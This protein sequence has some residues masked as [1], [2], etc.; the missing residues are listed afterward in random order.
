MK[1]RL[2]MALYLFAVTPALAQPAGRQAP[3]PAR[4]N[5]LGDAAAFE[6]DIDALF[7]QGGL[8]VEQAAAK[9]PRVSPTVMRRVAELDAAAAQLSAAKLARVPIISANASYTRLSKI[10]PLDLGMG[11]TIDF[12][13][14]SYVTQGQIAVPLS[15]HVLRFPK[16]IDAAEL[17][18]DSARANL[19][20]GAVNASQDARLA[21]FEVVRARLQVIVAERQLVQV[22]AV[23]KQVR[24]LTDAQRLSKADLMRVE[25]QEAEAELQANQLRYLAQLREEQL[26]ILIGIGDEVQITLDESARADV[27]PPA[28]ADLDA[29]VKRAVDQRLE[30]R[31]INFGIQ[32]RV[33]QRESEKSNY[34]PVLSAFAIADYDNPNQRVFPLE[35]KFKFTWQAGVQVSWRLNDALIASTTQR[36]LAAE[37]N[38]LRADRESLLLGTRIEVLAA[39]QGVQTAALSVQTTAKQLS[40]AEESYRVRRELLAADRATTIDMIDAE[41]TLTRARIDAIN[42]RVNLRVA[43]V[44]LAHALG[45]DV[46]RAAK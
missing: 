29:L 45:D 12:P 36:R 32:A 2:A 11:F 3:A 37:T 40:S 34:W 5:T 25:S 7:V 44:S 43:I 6:K 1:F 31:A 23:L 14:N 17:S 27:T 41:N 15:D 24:A 38:Q 28:P 33:A 22:R 21:Y 13:S 42:A 8:T 20:S 18:K 19:E 4:T 35:E 46:P 30:F 39:E 9:A 10:D 26:R 16:L